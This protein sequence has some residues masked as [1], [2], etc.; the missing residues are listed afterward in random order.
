VNR[1]RPKDPRLRLSPELYYHMR[2]QVLHRDGW[3]CQSCGTMSNLEVHHKAFRSQA[4]DDSEENLIT[5]CAGC[6]SLSTRARKLRDRYAVGPINNAPI[7]TPFCPAF[8]DHRI[9]LHGVQ[10]ANSLRFLPGSWSV[11]VTDYWGDLPLSLRANAHATKV[12][13]D[14]FMLQLSLLFVSAFEY[15]LRRRERRYDLRLPVS[16]S[17]HSD[18]PSEIMAVSENISSHGILL[19]SEAAIPEGTGIELMSLSGVHRHG[20]TPI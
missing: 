10:T 1:I 9:A 13:F 14:A 16:V 7:F 17:V 8:L 3:R 18:I 2:Q 20:E 4:S 11:R 6:H 19:S 5:L 12:T 15:Q